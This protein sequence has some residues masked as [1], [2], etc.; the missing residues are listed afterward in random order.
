[1]RMLTLLAATFGWLAAC[2]AA[3]ADRREQ[4]LDLPAG[5]KLTYQIITPD[6]FKPGQTAP[7]LLVFPP[8]PQ[9][10]NTVNAGLSVFDPL[11]RERGWV[12][13]SPEAPSARELFFRGGEAHIPA[14]LT[15][16]R[17]TVNIEGRKVHVVGASNGGISA[18]H[19]AALHPEL[20][21]SVMAFPGYLI[22][23][24]EPRLERLKSIPVRLFVGSDDQVSWTDAAKRVL[25]LGQKA[26]L[27]IALDVRDAQGHVI[28]NLKGEE[29]FGMLDG[30]RKPG[31]TMSP[32]AAQ[33][34]AVLDDFHDAAAKADFERYFGLF[35][36]EGVFIGTDASERWTLEEFKA[37]AKPHFDKGKAWTY[38]PRDRHVDLSPDGKM[39][40]FD[41]MLDHDKYGVC[42]GTGVL[43]KVGDKWRV[44]QYHLTVPV[45]NELMD[46][47]VKMIKGAEKKK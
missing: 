14:L 6:K 34:A 18:L 11:C 36:P 21:L 29:L 26:K 46:R 8:G 13:V 19:F 27:D 3:L 1:M 16:L 32:G 17:K 30:F 44:S 23:E 38:R 5:K 2:G 39:A 35:A 7:V 41:E 37:Y 24:D 15:E 42:R 33:V 45:P 4:T 22:K 25:E 40:W 10:A 28:T 43:R 9:D 31:E 20:V 12:V 47:V